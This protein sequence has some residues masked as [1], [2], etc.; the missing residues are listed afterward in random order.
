ME[1]T[2]NVINSKKV[3][4]ALRLETARLILREWNQGD[5]SDLID[6]LNDLSVSKS[7]AFVPHPYTN[8]DAERWIAH[9]AK[10]SQKEPH[11]SDYEFAI[12]LKSESTVIVG[13]SLIQ[14]S[15]YHG[16]AG[17]GIWLNT[18]YQGS[19]YGSEAFGGEG[20]ICIRRSQPEKA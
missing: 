15:Q 2:R 17:G 1:P 3:D 10:T 5:I 4:V 14:I 6:G 12:E 16:T 8:Q 9:C 7:L 20:K 11:Q 19:G 18:G 13:V